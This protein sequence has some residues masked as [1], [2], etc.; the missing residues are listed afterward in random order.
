MGMTQSTSAVMVFLTG[1]LPASCHKTAPQPK[2]P[3]TAIMTTN[4]PNRVLGEI[5]LTNHNETSFQLPTGESC[6]FTP[7]MID[8][9]NVQL[10]LAVESK[11]DYGETRQ[12]NCGTNRQAVGS[13]RWA[14]ESHLHAERESGINL[15]K[16]LE[17]QKI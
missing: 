11:N 13:G 12:T 16:A 5:T 10:T 4:S 17:N 6:T 15:R 2:A 1:L 3:V 14:V 9:H 7:K 8:R